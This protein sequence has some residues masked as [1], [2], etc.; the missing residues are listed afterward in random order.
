MTRPAQYLDKLEWEFESLM[1]AGPVTTAEEL[2]YHTLNFV[3]TAWHMTDWTFPHLAEAEKS[4]FP[5]LADFQKW[6][7]DSSRE[8]AA[9]RDLAT[10]GKHVTID[11]SPDAKIGVVSVSVYHPNAQRNVVGE[12]WCIAVDDNLFRPD[13]FCRTVITFWHGVLEMNGL[14]ED[15]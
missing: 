10:G 12:V 7:K 4:K 3:I 11:R 14:L 1:K 8:I 13:D 6:V 9:T 15:S 5:K 2:S